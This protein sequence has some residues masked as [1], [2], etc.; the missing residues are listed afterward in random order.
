M[1]DFALTIRVGTEGIILIDRLMTSRY[2]RV[3]CLSPN[4]SMFKLIRVRDS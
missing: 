2:Y 4:L 3:L 1:T